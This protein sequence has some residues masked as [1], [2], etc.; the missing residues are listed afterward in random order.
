MKRFLDTISV[1]ALSS[2]TVVHSP[3]EISEYFL[4]PRISCISRGRDVGIENFVASDRCDNR[5]RAWRLNN[6]IDVLLACVSD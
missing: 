5:V 3:C 6:D 2:A 4:F 1:V